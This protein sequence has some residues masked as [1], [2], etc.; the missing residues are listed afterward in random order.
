ERGFAREVDQVLVAVATELGH[1]RAEDPD[2][3]TAR[4]SHGA[5][6]TAALAWPA[7]GG[8]GRS[9][10]AVV[11]LVGLACAGA[12]SASAAPRRWRTVPSP[13][14]APHDHGNHLVDV[15]C[16]RA[17]WCIA[18]GEAIDTRAGGSGPQSV[19]E[20]WDGQA[21]SMVLPAVAGV[22]NALSGVTCLADD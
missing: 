22:A 5:Q 11:V 13:S 18:V 7:V 2:V 10:V 6:A 16:A 1:V 14:V 15:S 3:V 8:L 17:D 12:T 19:I 9:R 4:V 21:W 20:Q